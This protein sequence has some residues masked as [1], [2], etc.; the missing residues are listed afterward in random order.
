[1]HGFLTFNNQG[2][3]DYSF[4]VKQKRK[5]RPVGEPS[6]ALAGGERREKL[7]LV[8]LVEHLNEDATNNQQH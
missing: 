1:L 6:G 4:Y 5:P 7:R 3:A 8:F 2:V